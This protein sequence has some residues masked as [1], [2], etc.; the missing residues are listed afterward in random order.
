MS[1]FTF[2]YT[3]RPHIGPN[4]ASAPHA[5]G[6]APP[7][8]VDF[9]RHGALPTES[10]LAITFPRGRRGERRPQLS[11]PS[12]LAAAEKS[13]LAR[14]LSFPGSRPRAATHGQGEGPG[15]SAQSSRQAVQRCAASRRGTS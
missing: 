12:G 7:A 13:L 11:V 6:P 10:H 5:L 8:G 15:M 9:R 3:C 2:K 4:A 14:V 1:G